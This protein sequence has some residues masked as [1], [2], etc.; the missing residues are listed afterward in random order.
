M[1]SGII[2]HVGNIE[3]STGVGL[4]VS[5][6]RAFLKKLK[7]GTSV[8]V[9]GAC[10]TVVERGKKTFKV[11]IMPE[12]R[13]RTNLRTLSRGSLVNLELPVT[14]NTLLSGHIVQ[15]HV[16]DTARLIRITRQK[17]A[18]VLG[19]S[20]LPALSM[21]IVDKG[22]VAVNGVSLTVI[23]AKRGHFTV[24]IVPH[25]WRSTALRTLK[26]NDRV[27]VEVDVIGK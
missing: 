26:L 8:A 12:T 14:P 23:K 4:T 3:K 13:V 1:F 6:P 20:V 5:A 10:L 22:P 2:S 9:Q 27:N 16:D 7:V 25:T 19:F 21:Y 11:E 18:R 17:N 24:G 15:G